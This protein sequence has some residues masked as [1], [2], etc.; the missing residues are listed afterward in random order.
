MISN[1]KRLLLALAGWNGLNSGM[2]KRA[3]LCPGCGV[4][5][6]VIETEVETDTGSFMQPTVFSCVNCGRFL[7]IS[8]YVNDLESQV[9]DIYSEVAGLRA[10]I[11]KS[12]ASAFSRRAK[13]SK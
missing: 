10:M 13:K 11:S 8:S 7:G 9:A 1:R 4:N 2:S 6:R 12:P 5:L 3:I